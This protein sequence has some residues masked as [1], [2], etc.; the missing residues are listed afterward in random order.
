[1]VMFERKL[2][3][4]ARGYSKLPAFAAGRKLWMVAKSW[5]SRWLKPYKVVPQVV[6]VQLVYKYYN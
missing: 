4:K 2:L 6:S 1:M 5:T 3:A